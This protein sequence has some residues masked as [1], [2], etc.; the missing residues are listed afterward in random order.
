MNY[1]KYL[2]AILS[3]VTALSLAGLMFIQWSWLKEGIALNKELLDNRMGI[4][5][6]EIRKEIKKQQEDIVEF[7][8][9]TEGEQN[10]FI[11]SDREGSS[12]IEQFI[13]EIVDSALHIN[14]LPVNYTLKG[15][16]T[17]GYCLYYAEKDDP[18]FTPYLSGVSDIICL[19]NHNHTDGSLDFV[20]ELDAKGYLLAESS[21]FLMPSLVFLLMLMGIF[22]F[23][24]F[25][26]NRQKKLSDLKTDFINNLTH[27][28]KTPIFTIGLSAK[29][30]KKAKQ[31]SADEKL[32]SYVDLISNEN[33]RLKTQVDKVLQMAVISTGKLALDK[34]EVDIHKMAQKVAESFRVPVEE[35]GGK[36]RLVF[37]AESYQIYADETHLTNAIYNMVDN[38]YKYSPFAPEILI[39]VEEENKHLVLHII[40]HG[41]GMSKDIQQMIF[42]R[43]YRG[44]KDDRH[45]VKGFGLG[46]SYV[47]SII[48]LHHGKIKV[49]S[50][51][52][53]GTVFSIYLPRR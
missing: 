1:S 51:E 36:I 40:D 44:Q 42:D 14:H 23:I 7:T 27:E 30:L 52:G 18:Y 22:T 16:T 50:K 10:L 13:Y 2:V 5:K 8:R 9:Q 20:I 53:E 32:Y 39:K 33:Q 26:L 6:S 28:F 4:I 17:D 43:F 11:N 12:L 48:D 25:T 37:Q 46:L 19:C 34:S 24:I 29:M 47:K 38:A 3:G 49:H 21:G 35:K 45:D 31:V 15:K 41:M